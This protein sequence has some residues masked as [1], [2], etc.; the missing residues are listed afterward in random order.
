MKT[1]LC[2][3]DS[4]TW[5]S[6]PDQ[7]GTRHAR[8]DRWPEVMAALLGPEFH[9]ISDG[10][11]GRTTA[12]STALADCD[13]NGAQTLPTALYAHAPLDA[14]ILFLGTN[15]LQVT[16]CG[17]A[18]AALQGMRRLIEITQRHAPRM[19][20]VLP[21]KILIIAPPHIVPSADP[22]FTRIVPDGVNQSRAIAPLYMGLAA[23]MGVHFFDAAPIATASPVDGIHLD[24]K[25][26]R[27]IGVALAPVIRELLNVEG[28]RIG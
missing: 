11:R 16:I 18:V 25:N 12:Y 1:I 7:P 14:V 28:T 5:G 23:E 24:A 21:P 4:I 9:I 19:P 27:A 22:F 2:Y 3:G 17:A 10:L 8:E 15:D 13:R 26:T 6:N 20:G